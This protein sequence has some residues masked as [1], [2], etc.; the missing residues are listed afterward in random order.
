MCWAV[1]QRSR[2]R[3]DCGACVASNESGSMSNEGRKTFIV[4][5]AISI[6]T[7]HR[8]LLNVHYTYDT[9]ERHS[10][11][12]IIRIFDENRDFLYIRSNLKSVEVLHHGSGTNNG[13]IS[14]P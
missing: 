9:I 6:S 8:F 11:T 10:L 13:I 7:A 2:V 4:M 3:L 14:Q 1:D 5:Y 12:F